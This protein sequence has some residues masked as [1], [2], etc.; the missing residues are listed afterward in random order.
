MTRSAS[1]P[2]AG[3]RVA[4]TAVMFLAASIG[5]KASYAIV[6]LLLASVL[7]QA[8]YANYGL[9]YALQTAVTT[10]AV[11][12]LVEI[13]AGRLR[14]HPGPSEQR[15]LF[16][17]ITGLFLLTAV[18]AIAL[19]S[20]IIIWLG[21]RSDLLAPALAASML[22]VVI[23]FST[24]QASFY[25]VEE[26]HIVSL[27]ASAGIPL[28]ALVGLLG[29]TL[30]LRD[31]SSMFGAALLCST[32]LVALIWLSGVA[33]GVALPSRDSANLA[34]REATPFGIAAIF[35]W[36]SGY[37]M[38]FFLDW[39][40][41]V[42]DVAVYTFLYTAGSVG[43]V[44]A[45]A[46]NMVWSPRFYRLFNSD[47]QEGAERQSRAFFAA[48]AILLGLAGLVAVAIFPWVTNLV[49]GHLAAYG[50][51]RPELALLL[52]SYVLSVP[53][54]HA[55]NYYLVTGAGPAFMRVSVLSGAIGLLAWIAC[56]SVLGAE[57][58]YLG[59]VL[60]V[61]IRAAWMWIAARRTWRILPPVWAL[62]IGV[63][64]PFFGVLLPSP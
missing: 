37:G 55:Q 38:A 62:M 21:F 2:I 4:L 10:L 33:H 60:Q 39:D 54:W 6:I 17:D 51:Y 13:T 27:L 41:G 24:L 40:L 48:L 20:P 1:T 63:G 25:R 30:W 35:A 61:A 43:Q 23:A 11:V 59:L 15:R 50:Q 5:V 32:L 22:G 45:N 56:I 16:R 49:G 3:R 28:A 29:A 12:G 52:V 7:P 31:L 9:L 57:G 18:I 58:L 47:D 53:V 46:M 64:L 34:A 14:G 26:R 8:E 36:G 44:I 42:Q 19:A